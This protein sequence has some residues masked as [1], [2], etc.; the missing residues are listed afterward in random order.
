MGAAVNPF[1][2]ERS[3]TILVT[4]GAGYIGSHACKA[5]SQAG[6]LPV[7][8]D[9]LSAGRASAVRWG[10][11]VMGD[12]ADTLTLRETVRRFGISAVLHFAAFAYVAESL[13]QPR[14]YF[15]NN[16]TK[17]VQMLDCLL[18]AGVDT[19]VLSST[20]ATYGIPDFV[21]IN[22]DHPQRPINPYGESKL[23]FEKVLSWYGQAYKLKWASLRYFNAAGADP[24]GETGE[25]PDENV[26][27][28]PQAIKAALGLRPLRVFGTDYPTPD[29]TAVRDFVHV[30]DLAAAHVLALEYLRAG[31]VS[32]AF[33]LG[34]GK[35]YSVTEVISA[36]ESA[37]ALPVKV[38]HFPRRPGDPAE[39]IADA[40]LAREE[41]GWK[42]THS[43]LDQIATTAWRWMWKASGSEEERQIRL[44]LSIAHTT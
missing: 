31:N 20:C 39:M 14:K 29:G 40:S 18:D 28:I 10:P 11:L 16:L 34:S 19:I 38:E 41:L 27:L 33:N 17:S 9:D 37:S 36:I 23:A 22:E 21:P 25:S 42:L 32:R 3:R 15:H 44:G 2:P 8:Y 26:R 43:S 4:G 5:L 30:T 7:A 24:E 1:G 12:I 13:E 35:G 6:L